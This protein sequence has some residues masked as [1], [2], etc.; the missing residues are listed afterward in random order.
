MHLP[1][2]WQNFPYDYY[3]LR[4]GSSVLPILS[5]KLAH[6]VPIE[7]ASIWL[8]VALYNRKIVI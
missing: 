5:K 3:L 4:Y 8:I 2:N 6:I 1:H 7:E